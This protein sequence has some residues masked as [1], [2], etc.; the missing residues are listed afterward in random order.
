[1]KE[2]DYAEDYTEGDEIPEG[3]ILEEV[4]GVMSL[5]YY[6]TRTVKKTLSCSS[7]P[8]SYQLATDSGVDV[9]EYSKAVG[10]ARRACLD[11]NRV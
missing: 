4:D 9:K 10:Y 2:L 5:C 7:D 3:A 8:V 6:K 11:A 1:M